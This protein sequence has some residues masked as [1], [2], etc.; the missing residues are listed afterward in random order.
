MF[1]SLV[2]GC[3]GLSIIHN[4]V[5]GS[6]EYKT[7]GTINENLK[8]LKLGAGPSDIEYKIILLTRIWV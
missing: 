3:S 8:F 6:D 7:W 1:T 5:H 2:I 4:D